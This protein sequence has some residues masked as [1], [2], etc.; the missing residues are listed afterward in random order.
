MPGHHVTFP[1]GAKTS[2]RESSV[3]EL[4]TPAMWPIFFIPSSREIE[5]CIIKR[6]FNRY[7]LSIILNIRKNDFAGLPLP[8]AELL[9]VP[10]GTGYPPPGEPR[11][12]ARGNHAFSTAPCTRRSQW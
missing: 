12:A 7:P 4:V 1:N 6:L 10:F 11:T 5:P 8:T 3:E 9:F 2:R